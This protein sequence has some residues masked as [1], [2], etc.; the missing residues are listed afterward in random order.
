MGFN[1]FGSR[2]EGFEVFSDFWGL[3]VWGSLCVLFFEWPSCMV[4]FWKWAMLAFLAR[5]LRG[6]EFW[7]S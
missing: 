1:V 6:F 4:N 2:G 5:P 3:L 7:G